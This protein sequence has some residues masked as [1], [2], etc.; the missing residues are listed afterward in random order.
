MWAPLSC[1]MTSRFLL[2]WGYVCFGGHAEPL[3]CQ[4]CCVDFGR[5]L[6]DVPR[7]MW[8]YDSLHG[9]LLTWQHLWC[10][11]DV[12]VSLVFRWHSFFFFILQPSSVGLGPV[13]PYGCVVCYHI[14]CCVLLLVCNI[15]WVVSIHGWGY[16]TSIRWDFRTH[17]YLIIYSLSLPRSTTFASLFSGVP[18]P[19]MPLLSPGSEPLPSQGGPPG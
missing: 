16:F 10:V 13:A 11:V 5:G 9:V 14:V 1:A 18:L 12:S 17:I 3:A 7:H 6:V 19:L 4:S 2:L 8:L 15:L